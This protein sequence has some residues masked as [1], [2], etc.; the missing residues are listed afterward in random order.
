MSRVIVVQQTS[1]VTWAA[2]PWGEEMHVGLILEQRLQRWSNIKSALIHCP[3]WLQTNFNF[4]FFF[5][6]GGGGE[7]DQNLGRVGCLSSRLCIYSFPNKSLDYAVLSMVLCT[8]KNPWNH[9]IRIGSQHCHDCTERDV[10]KNSLMYSFSWSQV[11]NEIP[12]GIICF[13]KIV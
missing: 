12:Q 11:L 3:S 5:F 7:L 1:R 13:R 6:W 9:S 2:K 4:H 10:K 8:A